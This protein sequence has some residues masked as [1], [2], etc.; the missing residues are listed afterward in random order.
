MKTRDIEIALL[1]AEC[2]AL[3]RHDWPVLRHPIAQA[4]AGIRPTTETPSR[5]CN[6]DCLHKPGSGHDAEGR[7][8]DP[9]GRLHCFREEIVR[10]L[11]DEHGERAAG[12][13]E[14]HGGS[15]GL[16]AL[17]AVAAVD[18][19]SPSSRRVRW[20]LSTSVPGEQTG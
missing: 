12:G 19:V 7:V 11:H 4:V 2:T 8:A 15:N 16:A 3:P 9:S 18:G 6:I 14:Y 13:P 20:T 17:V 5:D 10:N 1:S